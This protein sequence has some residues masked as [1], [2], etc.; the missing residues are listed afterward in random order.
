MMKMLLPLMLIANLGSPTQS[1]RSLA[2]ATLQRAGSDI[3]VLPLLSWSKEHH[4]DLEVRMRCQKLIEYR[5]TSR[6]I[7][8]FRHSMYITYLPIKI[9]AIYKMIAKDH[10]IT[11]HFQEHVW[12]RIRSANKVEAYNLLVKLLDVPLVSYKKRWAMEQLSNMDEEAAVIGYL[13]DNPMDEDAVGVLK[14]HKTY[15]ALQ[16]LFYVYGK[17]IFSRRKGFEFSQ[18]L[19]WKMGRST[20]HEYE[21]AMHRFADE[22]LKRLEVEALISGDLD[23]MIAFDFFRRTSMEKPNG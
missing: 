23:L 3:E 18:P 12:P 15:E 7:S 16:G 6:P 9:E 22:M 11:W 10:D 17:K 19:W 14:R 1:V 5:V 8:F 13:Y 20:P 2:H 21:M 4:K